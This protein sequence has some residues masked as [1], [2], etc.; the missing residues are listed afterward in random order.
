MY[1]F[2]HIYIYIFIYEYIFI[3]IYIYYINM[4]I[5]VCYYYIY[6]YIYVG[7]ELFNR[8]VQKTIYNEKEARDLVM[9]LL[10]AVKYCHDRFDSA[11]LLFIG[12]LFLIVIDF[13][14]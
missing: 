6:M 10:S 13:F 12:H 5:Y 3:Y 8:I 7:G 2:T 11:S 9:K 1:V 14:L 4:Y